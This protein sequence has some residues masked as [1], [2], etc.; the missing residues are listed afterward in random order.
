MATKHGQSCLILGETKDFE[1]AKPNGIGIPQPPDQKCGLCLLRAFTRAVL[2]R[3]LSFKEFLKM[4]NRHPVLVGDCN[5]FSG[6]IKGHKTMAPHTHSPNRITMEQSEMLS[7][8]SHPRLFGAQNEQGRR[9]VAVFRK[10]FFVD[11]RQG[12]MNIGLNDD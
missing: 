6:F 9:V 7:P 11:V 3:L 2:D 12:Q 4:C 8:C 10:L 1:D 5:G